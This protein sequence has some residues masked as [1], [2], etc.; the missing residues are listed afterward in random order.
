MR[1]KINYFKSEIK[2]LPYINNCKRDVALKL[3]EIS[4]ILRG[5]KGID[6]T[7][8]MGQGSSL[9]SYNL[10]YWLEKEQELIKELNAYEYRS[11]Y[12]TRFLDA[13]ELNDRKI[14]TD[15]YIKNKTL[16]NVAAFNN[17]SKRTIIRKIDTLI[18]DYLNLNNAVTN[19]IKE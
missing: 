16:E 1:D 9:K 7:K 13:L 14:I 5:I 2:N 17:Y 18:I 19:E 15:V 3:E 8:I 11:S 10:Y 6:S 12:I 4:V